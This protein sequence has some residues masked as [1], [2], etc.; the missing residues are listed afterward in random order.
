MCSSKPSVASNQPTVEAGNRKD[1]KENGTAVP[2]CI[3]VPEQAT[4]TGQHD[5]KIFLRGG[6]GKKSQSNLANIL[7]N[8]RDIFFIDL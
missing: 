6:L 4:S 7:H 2:H 1:R 3:I 8:V 5:I